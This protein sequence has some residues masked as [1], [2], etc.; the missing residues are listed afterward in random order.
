MQVHFTHARVYPNQ[1]RIAS[2]GSIGC[3]VKIWAFPILPIMEIYT[4]PHTPMGVA[5]ALR[6]L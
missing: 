6:C 5:F 4:H 1:H 2:I 3:T